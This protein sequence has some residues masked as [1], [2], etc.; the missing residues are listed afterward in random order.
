[1]LTPAA[2]SGRSR[3]SIWTGEPGPGEVR[4]C[5]RGRNHRASAVIGATGYRKDSAGRWSFACY[6]ID[7]SHLKMDFI[8]IVREGG[9]AGLRVVIFDS[10]KLVS[11][12][13]ANV[14]APLSG[15]AVEGAGNETIL[16]VEDA[17][18]VRAYLVE[19][20]RDLNY[21]VL[22]AH[23][24]VS[25]LGL[26]ENGEIHIDLLLTDVVLPGMNGRQLAEQAKNRRPDLK[27]LFTTGYSRNAIVHQGRLDPGVAMIQKPITQERLAARVRDLLDGR[28]H[29]AG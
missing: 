2:E 29:G 28:V 18:D 1:M 4:R 12:D 21:R 26:I 9:G 25:A 19:L 17:R 27:V 8:S 22:G 20:L 11:G 13:V 14:F 7:E 3:G 5:H 15:E 6:D 16:V 24:A 10:S 23:D